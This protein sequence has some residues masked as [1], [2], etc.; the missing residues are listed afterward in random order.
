MRFYFRIYQC[1]DYEDGD[2]IWMEGK[3]WEDAERKVRR[4]YHSINRLTQL[5]SK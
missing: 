1:D 5:Y 3:S 2:T 4:E